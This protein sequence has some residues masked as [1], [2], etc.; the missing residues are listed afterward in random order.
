[1]HLWLLLALFLGMFAPAAVAPGPNGLA[2]AP[3]TAYAATTG[4]LITRVYSDKA[5]YAPGATVTIKADLTNTTGASWSGTLGL[6]INRLETQVHTATSGSIS[7][8]N[9]ASTTVTFTWTAPAGDYTGYYA[10]ISAGSTDFGGTGIDVSSSP[11]RFPRYGYI[12]DFPASRTAQQSADM[13]NQLVQDYHLNMFQFY[14]WMWRHEKLIKRTSGVIDPTWVDLFDRTLA[15]QTIQNDIGAA[16]TANA[17]AMAYVMNYA[18]REG[19][20]GMWGVDPAWGM[21]SDTAHASQ[22]NVNFNNGKYLWLFNPANA[23]WQNWMI[24]EYTDA[25]NAAGFDGLQLDQ[26]GQ[27][28]NVY[29]YYGF[30]LY[31]PPTFPQFTH[32]VKAALLANNPNK[33][34]L[35][36]NVVNGVVDGWAANQVSTYSAD[37]FDY[38]EIWSLADTYNKVRNY[39]EKQRRNNGG[40]ALVLAGY[41]N[42]N[43]DIGAKY[44]AESA[45]LTSVATNT[46]HPGYTGS[47]FVDGF[48]TVGDAITWTINA[49]EAGAYS[50]VFRYGNA[51]GSV[52]NRNVYIDGVLAGKTFFVNQPNWDTWGFQGDCFG[53]C[54][55]ANLTAGSHTIKLAYDSGNSGAINVDH[56]T[57]GQFEDSSIRL[58]DAAFFASGATHIELGDQNSMLAHEYFPNKSKSMRNSLK[59]A[60]RDYYG[61]ATAYE[62]LLFDPDVVPADQGGQWLSLTTGQ[63]LSGNAAAGT[64]W[65]MVKRKSNYDIVHLINLIGNDDQWRNGGV[66][67]TFQTNVGVKY[68]PGPNASITGVYLASPD[69]D[70]GVTSS[71]SYSTGS[72]SRGNYVQF[73]VPSLKYWDMIYVKRTVSQPGGG[74]YEAESAIKSSVSTNTDHT[75]YTGSGFVDGFAS[76]GDGVSFTIT[77]PAADSYTLRFR[78][79]NA[80]VAN[81]TRDLFVDGQGA[82]TLTFR[83][84]YNWDMWNTSETVVRLA[85]GVHQ[86]ALWFGSGN[87]GAI[88]LD[89][90][91]VLQQTSPAARSATSLWM[92]NWSNLVG[93]HMASKLSPIDTGTYGPRLAELHYSGDWPTNQLVDA[94]GFFRDQTGSV[95][96]YTNAHAF[97]SEAWFESDGTLTSRYLNYNGAALPVQVTKQY[98]MVPN[99]NFLVVKYTFQNLTNGA[100][101]FNVLEQAHLNN[102]TL[103]NPSPN[104]QHGWWDVSRNALGADMSQSGQFYIELGAFQTMDSR[105][106]G[107]DANSNPA[108]VNSAPWYQFDTN[109]TLQNKGDLWTQRL[110]LGFQKTLSLP[111][112][113]SASV[114]FYYAI[115]STQAAAE[116]AADTARAQTA[117]YWLGQTATQYTNWLNAGTRISMADSGLNSAFDRSLVINKQSQQPAFGSWP[118]ATNPAYGYKVW[119]RDSAVTAMGMDATGHLSEAEKYWNWM[120][121]VQNADGSWHTNYSVWHANQWISFVEPEHDA[122]GLF[123]IGVYRHYNAVKASNPA[124]A[125][126]FLNGIWTQVTRAGDFI[127]NSVGANGFGAADASI[128]EEQVEYN[129]FT[130]VTYAEGLNAGKY[131]ATEKGDTTRATN[132]LSSAQTIKNAMLRSFVA[133]PYRGLWNISGRYFNR[134]VNTDGSARTLIDS[135]SDLI[136][137]FGMLPATDPL[138]RDHRIQVLSAV[139][140]D[141]W[142]LTRYSGDGFYYS[143]PYSP[144][145]QYEAA[146]AEPVWPQMS[147]YAAMQEHWAG[148]DVRALARLQW[149]ASR[150]GRGF[151]TPGEAVDWTNGQPLISTAAEPVT[152]AWYQMAVLSYLNQ[153]DPRLPGF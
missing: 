128:W 10:G 112:N 152:G 139:T 121:S 133:S 106:V 70:H 15:W 60:M 141:S 35:T 90:L 19:Y 37:D 68:Y 17:A 25:I 51:I 23:S 12:S 46:N 149:Y 69:T 49:P 146:A 61:F 41:M 22:Q 96:K 1:V 124:A 7:L 34:A 40:K 84:L 145:G 21:F 39:I 8:G 18:A 50:F 5:R 14:D 44:E 151:V 24:G 81:A 11:L 120:A 27:I 138:V 126:T 114:A 94:T 119:V 85:P 127:R 43:E 4:A 102:K 97:D 33:A 77:A 83:N 153:F 28:D 59:A 122:I 26:M 32:S 53:A 143:S 80:T 74:Q 67:P 20:Q 113:G 99:Q 118:A 111:A 91:V 2:V 142:G 92:N 110:D 88:N 66:Q 98:A 54:V 31:V 3:A 57:L 75:G 87:G 86:V 116:S 134:A 47:G 147:M 95:V 76:S 148:N 13:I 105:Q 135:S 78:Y 52:A 115:G 136:W 48:E 93:V 45:A 107:D 137:V 150:T 38:S 132:Y 140:H 71:L 117:D 130:Q 123:L 125:T 100:R 42:Y 29:D 82:G 58:A 72:D 30:S 89:N 73:T 101:T 131:L 56:L 9:G 16:H 79:A 6:A 55:Q 36:F 129:T 63:S 104:W 65:Q 108:D 62:N 103:G 109:G 64:V 144:G